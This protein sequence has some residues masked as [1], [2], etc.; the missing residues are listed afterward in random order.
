MENWEVRKLVN[1]DNETLDKITEW[2]YNWCGK[3]DGYSL[4]A[5]KC[6][7]KHSMEENRLPQTYGLFLDNEIIGMYQFAYDDLSV[8]PDIYPWLANVYIDE[9]YRGKG[10]GRKLLESVFDNAKK[11]INFRKIFLYAKH[12]GLYEKFGWTF[13]EEVDTFKKEQRIERLYKLDLGNE[14]GD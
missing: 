14:R 7:M 2:M 10:Y 5:V 12:I 4:E 13:I 6:F 11:N 8:R 9:K 3:R 1:V